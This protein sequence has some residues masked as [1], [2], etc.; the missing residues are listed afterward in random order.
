M[1]GW[2][3]DTGKLED[4]L[5]ANR[6]VLEA[7]DL[8]RGPGKVGHGS[9]IEGRVALGEGVE[10]VDSLVRG[11]AILG[12]GTRL[13]NAFVG[14]YTSIGDHCTLASCEIENS[15]VLSGSEIRDVDLR[16]DGSLVG[17]NV[18]IQKTD[19]KPKAYRFMVGDNSEVGDHVRG[20]S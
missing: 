19:F 3:K 11:P 8:H 4:M 17:R 7:L 5:E 18:R 15:I 14:P 12:D 2:W 6:I 1:R 13:E 20:T 10:I 9:T 16:I